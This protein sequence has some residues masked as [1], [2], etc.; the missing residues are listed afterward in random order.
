METAQRQPEHEIPAQLPLLPLR[1]IV[2][3]PFMMTPLVVEEPGESQLVS[4]I[5]AS[6]K[7]L[8]LVL[9]KDPEREQIGPEDLYKMGTAA[10][11]HR[12]LRMPDETR[13]L[14]VNGIARIRIL[15]V[16]QT[17]PYLVADVERVA[18]VIVEDE[19][20]AALRQQL[21]NVFRTIVEL[22]PHMPSELYIQALNMESAGVL[23]DLVTAN[24]NIEPA[25]RQ[26]VL[27]LIDVKLRLGHVL[28]L[29]NRERQMLELTQKLQSEARDQMDEAQRRFFLQQQLKQIRKELGED[30][31]GSREI[32]ELQQRI[33]EANMSEPAREA[34]TRELDRLQRMNPAAAEYTVARTYL[35]WLIELPWSKTSED[36]LDVQDAQR[37]LDEDHYDL[38]KVKE[39]IVEYLAVRKL[40]PDMKGPILCFVGPPGVGKTSL[41]RSI[42]RALGRKFHRISL[43]GVRDE[44]EIRGHRRTYVGALPGRIIQGIR[45]AGTRNPVFMLD[46]IDKLGADFRGDPSAALLEVLDPEQNHCFS[47]H[48]LEVPFDLSRVLFITTANVLTTIPPPL[49]DRME[50]L[51][52]PGYTEEEKLRIAKQYLIPRQRAENGLN[53][54]QFRISDA[55]IRTVIRDY[56]REAGLRNLEREIGTLCRKTA[57]KVAEGEESPPGITSKILREYLGPKRF[58]SEAALRTSVPGVVCG[59]AYTPNGGEVLFVEA[60]RMPG[61]KEFRLTGQLGDV[62]QESAQAA[63]SWVRTNATRLGIDPHFFDKSDLH[64]HVPAGHVPKD[65]PSAGV[66]IAA[67]IVSLLTGRKPRPKVGMTG[68]ITLRGQVM[69]VG[70]IK[71]KCLAARRA[72]LNTVI[73]PKRNEADLEDLPA[74]LKRDLSFVF[75]DT[76]GE[77]IEAAL[78]P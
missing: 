36:H 31:D 5:A 6:H 52:L 54:R 17:E 62:M 29:A 15:Q 40:N 53:A 4:D 73:L 69:P 67:A 12:M 76:V 55:A 37:I 63:L 20:L 11:L 57:R 42:A 26:S 50:V 77:A 7:M 68:E 9:V 51:T 1:N 39:R 28:E 66:T 75:V 8:G 74:E 44:A 41:G 49:L 33:E 72:G 65:G 32:E 61:K 71:E 3:F 24:L 78:L 64:V 18:D 46:E 27:E 43:G 56:T 25:Q 10:L 48:Y 30:E 23:A 60:T 34:A 47:D 16:V 19:E 38:E 59:L 22:S 70:G 2:T 58:Y 21:L 45:A 14:L 13:R 35:D